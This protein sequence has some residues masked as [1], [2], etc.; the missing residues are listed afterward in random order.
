M[1]KFYLLILLG[2]VVVH[3]LWNFYKQTEYTSSQVNR[4]PAVLENETI[5]MPASQNQMP[6]RKPQSLNAYETQVK[7]RYLKS[8]PSQIRRRLDIKTLYENPE[9]MSF[10]YYLDNFEVIPFEIKVQKEEN[11]N[12]KTISDAVIKE[13][14][15]PKEKFPS[16]NSTQIE[17][18]ITSKYASLDSRIK[19]NFSK[20]IWLWKEGN[21]LQAIFEI[22][23]D[24]SISGKQKSELWQVD[25]NNLNV[26]A[27]Y[28]RV[29][30]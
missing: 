28:D 19:V 14:Y 7:E 26:L 21:S 29:K 16:F 25:A 11:Q 23:V 27:K 1:K 9:F 10:G 2:F 24:Q 12:L 4:F 15:F 5:K 3:I 30:H 13:K 8:Y 6:L 17:K 20:A 18:S 22:R